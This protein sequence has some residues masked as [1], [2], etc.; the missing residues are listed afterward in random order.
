[1]ENIIIEKK[2]YLSSISLQDPQQYRFEIGQ[3]IVYRSFFG[4]SNTDDYCFSFQTGDFREN[5]E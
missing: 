5:R 3:H 1:M 4:I 2:I